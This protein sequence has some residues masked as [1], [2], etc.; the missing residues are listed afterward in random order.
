VP[1]QDQVPFK[2]HAEVAELPDGEA[3]LPSRRPLRFDADIIAAVFSLV[4]VEEIVDKL[5]QT[6]RKPERRRHLGAQP[7]PYRH[8]N[9]GTQDCGPICGPFGGVHHFALLGPQPPRNVKQR[10]GGPFHRSLV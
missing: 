10:R 3:D 6:A 7:A 4:P 8:L 1:D 9:L 2:H 5:G